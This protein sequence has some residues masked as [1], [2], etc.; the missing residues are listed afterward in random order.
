MKD[1][2]IFAGFLAVAIFLFFV[3]VRFGKL[4]HH[5]RKDNTKTFKTKKNTHVTLRGDL[6]DDKVL[7]EIE[8]FRR[9]YPDVQIVIHDLPTSCNDPS[10]SQ[11]ECQDGKTSHHNQ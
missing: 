5:I 9:D 11:K 8:N 7:E 1:I 3:I 2:L 4:L 10:T 6:K